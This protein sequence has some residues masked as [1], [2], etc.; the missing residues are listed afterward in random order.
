MPKRKPIKR[1]SKKQAGGRLHGPSHAQGGIPAKIQNGGQVELEGGEYIINAQTVNAVGTDYLD[2]L[3]STATTYHQGG[4]QSGQL[5]HGSN[6][7]KGGKIR[8]R[9]RRR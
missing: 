8:K 4:F 6:Y 1:K 9:K 7:R 2:K 5:G 3:N